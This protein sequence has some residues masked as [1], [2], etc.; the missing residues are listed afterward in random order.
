[1]LCSRTRA[2]LSWLNTCTGL[3]RIEIEIADRKVPPGSSVV[4]SR[5]AKL[6]LVF[7]W[8]WEHRQGKVRWGL[9]KSPDG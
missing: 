6:I 3:P 2:Q 1:M 5:Q 4:L 7:G 9:M 8:R